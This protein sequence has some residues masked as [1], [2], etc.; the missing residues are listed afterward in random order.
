M[1]RHTLLISLVDRGANG[2]VAGDDVR[3]IFSTS[4]TVDI[5]VIDNHQVVD[6]PIGTVDSRGCCNNTKGSCHCHFSSILYI[7]KGYIHSFPL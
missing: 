2:V 1:H 7:G 6:V 4:R 3:D 5:K